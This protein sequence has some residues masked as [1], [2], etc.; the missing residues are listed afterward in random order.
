MAEPIAY[1]HLAFDTSALVAS[2]WPIPS[3]ELA[4]VADRCR[5][6]GLPMLMPELV[7]A[8]TET[9]WMRKTA[10]AVKAAD[11]AVGRAAGRT[12][13]LAGLSEAS[14]PDHDAQLR[15]YRSAVTALEKAWQWVRVP[16]PD[17][18]L[19]VAVQQSVEH[20]P[21][22]APE[23]SDF[24]DSLIA[25]SLLEAVGPGDTVALLAK[26]E[27]FSKP[28]IRRA[29]EQR[30]VTLVVYRN[31]Q[32]AWRDTEAMARKAGMAVV[33]D[34]WTARNEQLKAQVEADHGRFDEF[35]TQEIRVPE[36]PLGIEGHVE[37]VR[38]VRIG[39]I[40]TFFAMFGE[41]PAEAT[42]TVEVTVDAVIGMW[43]R[44]EPRT[45]GVGETFGSKSPASTW[46]APEVPIDGTVL[47]SAV[48]TWP[49]EGSGQPSLEYRS[50]R[51]KTA[52]ESRMENQALIE[53]LSRSVD[54]KGETK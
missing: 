37:T 12:P 34:E 42:I 30:S 16:L 6:M 20:T 17:V 36:Y 50:A 27:Q 23:D 8:E 10:E 47:V 51:F 53:A 49:A 19:G 22:F 11:G 18:A 40:Q 32:E 21:P 52:E 38:R 9:V 7:L 29:A 1:T 39:S 54:Q 46:R 28:H 3:V 35:V 2:N 5:S 25:W 15:F 4:N 33:L 43:L 44:S 31:P 41:R 14:W 45:L 24:R 26:D 48:L 13:G